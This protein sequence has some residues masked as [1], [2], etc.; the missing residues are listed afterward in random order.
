MESSSSSFQEGM[1][2][3]SEN[4]HAYSPLTGIG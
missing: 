2:S 4:D 1:E 3:F